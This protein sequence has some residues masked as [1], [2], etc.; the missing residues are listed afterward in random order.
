MHEFCEFLNS[1][2][3]NVD[4]IIEWTLQSVF[5]NIEEMNEASDEKKK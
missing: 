3:E 2:S 4:E 1:E 5:D